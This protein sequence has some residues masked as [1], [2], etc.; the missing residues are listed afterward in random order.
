MEQATG[1][2]G[3]RQSG[4][5]PGGDG[6]PEANTPD[7]CP[8]GLGHRRVGGAPK[9]ACNPLAGYQPQHL[10]MVRCEPSL[11]GLVASEEIHFAE[12]SGTCVVDD[13]CEQDDR[14]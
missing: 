8:R 1:W 6:P 12:A 14:R 7:S 2:R 5:P 10:S 3:A 13:G 9:P 11:I 4:L